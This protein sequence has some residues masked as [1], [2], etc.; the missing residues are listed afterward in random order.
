MRRRRTK[1]ILHAGGHI[2]RAVLLAVTVLAAVTILAWTWQK[3]RID[4]WDRGIFAAFQKRFTS[5][6]EEAMGLLSAGKIDEGRRALEELRA[7]M[8]DVKGQDRLVV[9]NTAAI[10]SLVNV[11]D[12]LGEPEKALMHSEE[13]IRLKPNHYRFWLTHAF[14]LEKSGKRKEAIDALFM[15]YRIAPHSLKAAGALAE[16]LFRES[17][18][19]EA[20]EVLRGYLDANRGGMVALVV[21]RKGKT[22]E[23]TETTLASVAFTGTRQAFAFPVKAAGGASFTFRL[24]QVMDLN[25]EI[26]DLSVVTPSGRRSA[27]LDAINFSAMDMARTGRTAFSITGE[28][29]SVSFGLPEEFARMEIKAIEIE[30]VFTPNFSERLAFLLRGA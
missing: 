6:F 28:N 9:L 1:K 2:L 3:E 8:G 17:R 19:R 29:P 12:R 4:E 10:E 16:V 15:A 23:L 13:L 21:E 24:H 27:G 30:A 18:R 14:Q 26:T 5:G 20:R 25:V 22:H 7:L 11:Y